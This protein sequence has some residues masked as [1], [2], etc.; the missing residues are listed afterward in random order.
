MLWE[1]SG[2]DGQAGVGVMHES[3]NLHLSL[4]RV[5]L[6]RC[7]GFGLVA[8]AELMLVALAQVAGMERQRIK[9]RSEAGRAATRASL[10]RTGGPHSVKAEPGRGDSELAY[11]KR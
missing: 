3:P 9:E 4:H 6:A 5:G 1:K 7:A 10:E 2:S 8:G 11:G